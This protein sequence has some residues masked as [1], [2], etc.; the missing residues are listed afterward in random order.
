MI[1]NNDLPYFV[2][3]EKETGNV[4]YA[5]EAI[6][7]ETVRY[8]VSANTDIFY[9]DLEVEEIDFDKQ[10]NDNEILV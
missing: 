5:G 8:C 2:V 1:K 7:S 10:I 4:L 6:S 3:T 9:K